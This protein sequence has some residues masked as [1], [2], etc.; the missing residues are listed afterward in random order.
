ML[1]KDQN[2]INE[3]AAEYIILSSTGVGEIRDST[4]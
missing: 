3:S 4:Y 1:E 2:R